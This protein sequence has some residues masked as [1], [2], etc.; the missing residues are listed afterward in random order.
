MMKNRK[1]ILKQRP[2]GSPKNSDFDII[3][4]DIKPLKQNDLLLKTIYLS[5][6]PYMRGRMN[7]AKSYAKPIKIDSVMEGETISQVVETKNKNYKI[8]DIVIGKT[9]WQE[10]HICSPETI[11]K[12]NPD[13][14]PISTALGVLGMPGKTAFIG[15]KNFAKPKKGETIVVSAASGAVGSTVGQIAKIFG[16][17]VIGIVG[18]NEKLNYVKNV[19]KF[20]D[21]LNYKEDNFEENLKNICKNGI[22]IY[23]E[24]VHGKT[25]DAVLPLLN[26]FSRIPVCG[27]ISIYNSTS[28]PKGIHNLP[29]LFR[30]ILTK[31]IM[32]KGFLVFDHNDED[33]EIYEQLSLW[34]KDNKLIYKEDI[35]IGFEKTI[36][37]FIGLFKGNNFGKLIMQF[38]DDPFKKENIEL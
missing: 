36:E 37:T 12:I 34:I 19:L 5:L 30:Q 2:K 38:S 26:N 24:N 31:R 17:N 15:I 21:C 1:I 22:D 6:D 9:G 14:A 11:R 35:R 33:K 10:F 29:L 13:I 32:I 7:E 4:E 3:A 25:F 28:W 27:L 8:G 18:S 16:C 23:W 20:H